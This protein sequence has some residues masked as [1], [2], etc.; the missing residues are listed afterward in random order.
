M[1]TRTWLG[2]RIPMP[3]YLEEGGPDAN[4]WLGSPYRLGPPRA[5]WRPLHRWVY[6]GILAGLPAGCPDW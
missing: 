3:G 6:L 2:R 1:A 5:H 4:P